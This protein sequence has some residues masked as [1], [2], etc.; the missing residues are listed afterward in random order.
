MAEA[1]SKRKKRVQP[2]K[3]VPVAQGTPAWKMLRV[4]KVTAS[5]VGDVMA[6]KKDKSETAARRDYRMQVIT[7]MLTGFPTEYGFETSDMRWGI[8]HEPHARIIYGDI[9]QTHVE[10][11]PFLQHPSIEQA[12]ASPDGL[13]GK[14][15]MLEVKCP[16]SFTH[17]NYILENVV[18]ADYIPQMTWQLACDPKREWVDFMSFDPRMPEALRVFVKRF[19]RKDADIASAEV[20][21]KKFIDECLALIKQLEH[22]A[23]AALT[24]NI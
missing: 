24:P 9:Y 2:E 13:I 16:R 7:E 5:R 22:L 18:P 14:K 6:W 11:V 20:E 8:D 17:L 15:G 3:V 1:T 4:G 23:P 21:V 12:G 10:Q 19:Y